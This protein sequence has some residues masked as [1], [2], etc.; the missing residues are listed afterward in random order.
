MVADYLFLP[1]LRTL[2]I[3][4]G[5][6]MDKTPYFSARKHRSTDVTDLQRFGC[7]EHHM[8]NSIEEVILSSSHL[9]RLVFERNTAWQHHDPWRRVNMMGIVLAICEHRDSLEEL[10]VANSDA[11]ERHRPE[12]SVTNLAGFGTLKKLVIPLSFIQKTPNKNLYE[13]LPATLETLQRE[14]SMDNQKI[15]EMLD[16]RVN[17]LQNLADNKEAGLPSLTHVIWWYQQKACHLPEDSDDGAMY[18]AEEAFEKLAQ[19]IDEVGVKFRWVSTPTLKDTP[20]GRPLG[21]THSW[22][23]DP[24]PFQRWIWA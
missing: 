18:G 21:I 4:H 13:H 5:Y 3:Q 20:L 2:K 10:I 12:L 24:P 19:Q 7:Y 16:E 23:R 6:F 17:Q 8:S 1:S 15:D 11:A 14:Y 22:S 9:Q